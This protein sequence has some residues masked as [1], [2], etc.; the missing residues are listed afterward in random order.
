MRKKRLILTEIL[1]WLVIITGICFL[2]INP[3]F[4]LKGWFKNVLYINNKNSATVEDLIQKSEYYRSTKS[5]DEVRKIQFFLAFNDLEFTL[6]Y[7]DGTEETII[8]DNL[9]E[10][11][12]YIEKNGYSKAGVYFMFG[13][14]DIILCLIL[15]EIRKNVFKKIELIEGQEYYKN[16]GVFER[17]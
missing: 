3:Y 13:I 2:F 12:K 9:S 5:F 7:K 4:I 16:Y 15:N 8:D 14:G 1:L 11:E 17:R 6:Y 10:L